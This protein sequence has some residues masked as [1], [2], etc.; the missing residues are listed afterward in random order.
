MCICVQLCG[1]SRP[2]SKQ[3]DME[4]EDSKEILKE[5]P[6]EVDEAKNAES[7]EMIPEIAL[8]ALDSF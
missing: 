7:K 8:P 1:R 4:E 2:I 5:V 3:K 6:A